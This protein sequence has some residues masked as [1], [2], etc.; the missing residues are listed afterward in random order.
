M[1]SVDRD[2]GEH[3][4][5]LRSPSRRW[6]ILAAGAGL[7]AGALA[8]IADGY[9][10]LSELGSRGGFWVVALSVI[11][12]LARTDAMAWRMAIAFAALSLVGYYT[13]GTIDSRWAPPWTTVF[14]WGV[15]AITAA[16][17]LA[18]LS[19]W[20][21][22]SRHRAAPLAI[23]LIAGG[24]LGEAVVLALADSTYRWLALLFDAMAGLTIAILGGKQLRA[25]GLVT[26]ATAAG[27]A[28]GLAVI[29][30]VEAL[31]LRVI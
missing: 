10:T 4:L 3:R 19:H 9:Q 29:E 7:T 20:A 6:L 22:H 26:L 13:M 11:G 14:F 16:P 27:A 2:T 31:Y 28:A 5:G 12:I 1:T 30:A 17:A 24:L 25:P 15:A 23:G 21:W 18:W 8:Q